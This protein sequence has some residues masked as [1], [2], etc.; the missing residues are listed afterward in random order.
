MSRQALNWASAFF[1][2]RKEQLT[3]SHTAEFFL[4]KTVT[5]ATLADN[6]AVKRCRFVALVTD[7]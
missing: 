3:L 4:Q 6:Q 1:L 5:T 2:Q 7:S